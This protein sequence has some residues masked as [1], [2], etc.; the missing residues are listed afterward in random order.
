LN[1]DPKW[2]SACAIG[3]AESGTRP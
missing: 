3:I 2:P 1:C